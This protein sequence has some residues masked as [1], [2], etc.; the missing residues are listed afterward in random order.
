MIAG[1]KLRRPTIPHAFLI[2]AFVSPS[3]SL[4]HLF[5]QPPPSVLQ[6]IFI[7]SFFPPP[8][9][10]LFLST[11]IL[12]LQHGGALLGL[13]PFLSII[14]EP[15]PSPSLRQDKDRRI[16][17]NHSRWHGMSWKV[18]QIHK[19]SVNLLTFLHA[20]ADISW[21]PQQKYMCL[22][23]VLRHLGSVGTSAV[24]CIAQS[25]VTSR[26]V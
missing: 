6:S 3:L 20:V 24:S 7:S 23:A 4:I 14:Q 19:Y 17:A 1:Y 10:S 5:F 22:T 26:T 9:F 12:L 2:Q 15:N 21:Y 8:L 18:P 11:P 16:A 25:S 13:H